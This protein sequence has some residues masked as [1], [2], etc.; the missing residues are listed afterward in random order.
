[1]FKG[2]TYALIACLFWGLTYI[3]PQFMEG[4][5]SIEIVLCLYSFYGAFSVLI[6]LN[7]WLQG[8]CRY[9]LA[10]WGKALLFSLMS[11][12]VYYV[13]VILGLRY[14]TPA[15][16]ALILGISPI[17][18]ALYGNLRKKECRFRS[19]I[20]PSLMILVGLIMVNI[21]HLSLRE[22]ISEYLI[23]LIFCFISLGAWSWYVVANSHFL[24]SHPHVSSSDW[25][26]L[27]GVSTLV[28]IGLLIP[29]IA[30]FFGD[31]ISIEK[32]LIWDKT[33]LLFILGGATLG[34]LSSWLAG[35]LWN[36][37]SSHLPISLVG[38][39]TIFET[40]F[41]LL[42]VYTLEQRVPPQM[43]A[44]GI[45]ILFGAVLFGIRKQQQALRPQ[46]SVG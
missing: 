40:I 37:A 45:L 17:T 41:G 20:L 7:E 30:V 34:L 27:I 25:A 39:M 46:E 38:Q 29:L 36:R 18:I 21:P 10:I 31:Q 44:I 6:F 15:V 2:I 14:A 1:M 32:Y 12:F 4:F 35:F 19:L 43:E 26:T 33:L 28:W 42:F 11:T 24:K 22:S 23:G 13:S 16:C 3:V 8:D 5:S 9:P